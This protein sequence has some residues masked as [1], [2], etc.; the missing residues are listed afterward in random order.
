MIGFADTPD[1]RWQGRRTASQRHDRQDHCLNGMS[2]GCR[3][4]LQW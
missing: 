4:N 1:Y 2:T 3:E